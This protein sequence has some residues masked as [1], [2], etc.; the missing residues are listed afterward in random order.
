MAIQLQKQ[1]ARVSIAQNATYG[2]RGRTDGLA[3][4][5]F[6]IILVRVCVVYDN[7]GSCVWFMIILVRVCG[8]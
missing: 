1:S 6:M 8:L 7:I 3:F 4:V 5:W 2:T